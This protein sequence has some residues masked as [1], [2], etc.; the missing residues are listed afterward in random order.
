MN[1]ADIL[2]KKHSLDQATEQVVQDLIRSEFRGWTVVVI[3]HRLRAVADFDKV[4]ALQDGRVVEFDSPKALLEKGDGVF[5][6]LWRLQEGS[7]DGV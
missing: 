6:S 1:C 5:A 4:V 3:A 7:V 2:T